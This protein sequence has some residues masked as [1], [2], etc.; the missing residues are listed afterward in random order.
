[1]QLAQ[2]LSQSRLPSSL[3]SVLSHSGTISQSDPAAASTP[4]GITQSSWLLDSGASFHMT[5]DATSLHSCQPISPNF[6]VVIV[7]GT[8]IH[9]DN[10]STLHTIHFRILDVAYIPKLSLNLISVS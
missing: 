5:F 6:R 1:M 2:Q 9:I 10:R 8:T 4:T 7:D 3:V